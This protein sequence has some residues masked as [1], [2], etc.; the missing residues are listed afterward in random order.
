MSDYFVGEIRIFA[1]DYAPEHWRL[2][3]GEVLNVADHEVLFALIGGLFGGD[4]VKTFALPNL[5]GRLPIGKNTGTSGTRYDVAAVGGD[6]SVILLES[7]LPKHTH[8][9]LAST[10]TATSLVPGPTMMCGTTEPGIH[11]YNDLSTGSGDAL[12]SPLAISKE[13]DSQSH[14]NIMPCMG[15]TY[16]IAMDGIFP[17]FD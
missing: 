17:D 10:S 7:N 9:L 3:N 5:C 1:G 14:E 15:L 4:G 11:A 2:C 12:F 16:I 6:N 8:G 13:G